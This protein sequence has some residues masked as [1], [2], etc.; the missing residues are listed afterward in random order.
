MKNKR[1]LHK[2]LLTESERNALLENY[3]NT[4]MKLLIGAFIISIAVFALLFG[5]FGVF[6][7]GQNGFILFLVTSVCFS[8]WFIQHLITRYV[9]NKKVQAN[10]MYATEAIYDHTSGKYHHVY[11]IGYKKAG[12]E[13][14]DLVVR[15]P[16]EKE[17]E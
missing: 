13:G 11:L 7:D 2:R 6:I 15:E 10:K 4:D 8:I 5:L 14:Y 9:I 16:L 1:R 3:K 17:I 12:F